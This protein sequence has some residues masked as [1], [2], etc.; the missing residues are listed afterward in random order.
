MPAGLRMCLNYAVL[1]ADL[2]SG[3][4]LAGQLGASAFRASAGPVD[5]NN[6]VENLHELLPNGWILEVYRAEVNSFG[7]L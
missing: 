4:N 1:V 5:R 7:E 3:G 6:L 2:N